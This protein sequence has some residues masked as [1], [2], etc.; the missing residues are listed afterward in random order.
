MR[1][2]VP[3]EVPELHGKR[4]ALLLRALSASGFHTT[5]YQ[6][7]HARCCQIPKRHPF[8]CTARRPSR[9]RF[10][11]NP[12]RDSRFVRFETNC[13]FL[14]SRGAHFHLPSERRLLSSIVLSRR[15]IHSAFSASS[16]PSSHFSAIRT[17]KAR[18]YAIALRC[19]SF[20]LT[21]LRPLCL[22]VKLSS[23][24]QFS[25]DHP[26]VR[27]MPASSFDGF[28][29]VGQPTTSINHRSCKPSP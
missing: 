25:T 3:P 20:V 28:T 21:S 23:P 15:V 14:A 11:A 4:A 6:D 29:G 8:E 10:P 27:A 18:H 7:Q 5:Q 26:R 12:M 19:S 22:C 16:N 17:Q 9:R 1:I 24:S 13:T 2:P